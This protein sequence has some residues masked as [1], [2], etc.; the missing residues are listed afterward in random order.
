MRSARI[1]NNDR[2]AGELREVSPMEYEFRY[3]DAYF[4]DLAA[5][6]ISLTLPKSKQ[7]YR[8]DHL[9]SFF[10]NMLS[11]GHNKAYQCGLYKIDSK[12]DFGLLLATAHTETA[13]TITVKAIEV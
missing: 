12:D 11:E 6:A 8:S 4:A 7:L 1:F 9:F 10:A 5:P 13:G 2:L 3:D